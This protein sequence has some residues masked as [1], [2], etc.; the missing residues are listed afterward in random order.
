MTKNGKMSISELKKKKK[1]GSWSV[2][3][4]KKGKPKK[5]IKQDLLL[6]DSGDE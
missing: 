1:L 2:S 4:E 5:N 6:D 3:V